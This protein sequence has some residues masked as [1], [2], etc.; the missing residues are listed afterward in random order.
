[1]PG[2]EARRSSSILEDSA[3][4]RLGARIRDL[5][6]QRGLTLDQLAARSDVS[7]SMLSNVE[8][9]VNNP[10]LVAAIRI[11]EALGVGIAVLIGDGERREPVVARAGDAA[12]F[13][14]PTGYE[15]HLFPAFEDA[16]LELVRHVVPP[17]VRSEELGAH[18]AIAKYLVVEAGAVQVEMGEDTHTLTTGDAIALPAGSSYRFANPSGETARFLLVKLPHRT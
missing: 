17:G 13:V 4:P 15:R 11:A 5:R 2:Q 3:A 12:V 8:R 6:Q 10:T 16:E 9:G 1:M 14:D 7:R 18:A